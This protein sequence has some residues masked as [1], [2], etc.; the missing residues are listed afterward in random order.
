MKNGTM[1]PVEIIQ[2]MGERDIR[3]K[4]RGGESN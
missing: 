1:R 3:E 4:D 2:G